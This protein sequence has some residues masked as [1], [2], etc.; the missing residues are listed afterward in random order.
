MIVVTKEMTEEERAKVLSERVLTVVQIQNYDDSILNTT[1]P[2]KKIGTVVR[3]YAREI[4]FV[5]KNIV[6]EGIDSCIVKTSSDTVNKSINAEMN[7]EKHGKHDFIPLT[8]LFHVIEDVSKNA[9][10]IQSENNR[11]INAKSQNL[12]NIKHYVSGFCDE[13]SFYPVKIVARTYENSKNISVHVTITVDKIELEQVKK[14]A[15]DEGMH[16][17]ETKESPPTPAL[18]SFDITIPQLLTFFNENEGI[19][20][21]NMPDGLLSQKQKN[22]KNAVL[23]HDTDQEEKYREIY[24]KVN[25][26]HGIDW[27]SDIESISVYQGNKIVFN[28]NNDLHD[29]EVNVRL[30][31]NCCWG[32]IKN[33]CFNEMS[34]FSS[35]NGDFILQTEFYDVVGQEM[36]TEKAN[37]KN[38]VFNLSKPGKEL[39]KELKSR[40]SSV[41][42][43]QTNDNDVAKF[44]KGL[45]RLFP[46]RVQKKDTMEKRR[47]EDK[48]ST[49][50]ASSV[51][52]GRGIPLGNMLP[53]DVFLQEDYEEGMER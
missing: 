47:E 15:A 3:E 22:I 49:P 2:N 34:K 8:K 10:L 48:P 31:N 28:T 52:E 45:K 36:K 7:L 13:K 14:K 30:V 5:G 43:I 11:H 16:L 41:I 33:P 32:I 46:E 25:A 24:E 40:L 50:P 21:K 51:K 39:P 20:L 23:N 6:L 4:G 29:T 19:I 42:I 9:I 37:Y 17:D 12:R 27:E 35:V 38:S 26:T 18:P 53:K 1:D 44:V